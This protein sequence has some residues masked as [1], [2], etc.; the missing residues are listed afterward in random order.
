LKIGDLV[1][2]S[3]IELNGLLLQIQSTS[4]GIRKILVSVCDTVCQ[5]G[6]GLAAAGIVEIL[7]KIGRD[8]SAANGS[9]RRNNVFEQ[10]EMNGFYDE[11]PANYISDG[12]TI[13]AMDGGLYEHYIEFRNYMQEAVIELLGEGSKDVFIQLS[14]DG[15]G[16]GAALLAASHAENVPTS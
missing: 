11:L 2:I 7:K 1:Q 3:L 12:K 9:I 5:R 15:S 8:G 6:A 14:K 10:G 4:V 16:I 13:V